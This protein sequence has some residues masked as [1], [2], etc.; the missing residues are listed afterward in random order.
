MSRKIILFV[1]TLL[2]LISSACEL[3]PP[4]TVEPTFTETAGPT[5]DVATDTPAASTDT[6]VPPPT[7]TATV[8]ASTVVPPTF[9]PTTQPT[10]TPTLTPSM[11]P[12]E[13][14]YPYVVQ[15][16]SPVYMPNFAHPDAGCN[17]LGVAGQVFDAEGL[18]VENLVV[19]AGGTLD[20]ASIDLISMTGSASAYHDGGYEIVLSSTVVESGGTVWVQVKGLDGIPLTPKIYLNTHAVCLENLILLNFVPRSE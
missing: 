19:V 3:S 1:V 13:V 5:S 9:T 17:W 2:L 6:E 12:E 10:D 15:E 14:N 20:G 16:G 11:T 18:G 8:L 4:V 7:F